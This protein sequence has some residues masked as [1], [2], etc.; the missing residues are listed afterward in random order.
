MGKSKIKEIVNKVADVS[1]VTESQW[2]KVSKAAAYSTAA[3]FITGVL[4]SIATAL[5]DPTSVK[6]DNAL[7]FTILSAGVTGAINSLLVYIKQLYTPG[8]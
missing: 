7:I 6:F 8:E 1:P 2:K 5:N 3:G 4:L